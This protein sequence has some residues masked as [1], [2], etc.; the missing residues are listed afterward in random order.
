MGTGALALMWLTAHAHMLALPRA[1]PALAR[2]GR[3]LA[4]AGAARMGMGFEGVSSLMGAQAVS[5][6]GMALR[7]KPHAEGAPAA[8]V[9]TYSPRILANGGER[10]GLSPRER[11]VFDFLREVVRESGCG[12]VM[13][14]AGG[15]VRDK[16]LGLETDDID[17]ALDN[18]TGLCFARLLSESLEQTGEPLRIG[19]IQ[20]NPEQSKHLETVA[21]SI[22]GLSVDLVNLRSEEYSSE[23]RIPSEV[24]FG[25][26]LSDAQRRDL[27]I[28]SLFYNLRT[29]CIEDMTGRALADLEA[30][31]IDTPLAPKETL[32]DD[33]LRVLRAIRFA[34]RF[35]YSV[36]PA[37]REAMSD[38][39]VQAQLATKI[40]RERVLREVCSM[41]GA[42]GAAPVRAFRLLHELRL[43]EAVFLA[44]SLSSA[45]ASS[46]VA[47]DGAAERAARAH[48]A[49]RRLRSATGSLEVL[50]ALLCEGQGLVAD[51]RDPAAEVA[52]QRR[53][54]LAGQNAA[55]DSLGKQ[56][57]E[58]HED[59]GERRRLW[60]ATVL[61]PLRDAPVAAPGAQPAG[62]KRRKAPVPKFKSLAELIMRHGLKGMTA[63]DVTAILKMH[64]HSSDMGSLAETVTQRATE[65]GLPLGNPAL[66]PSRR[67]MGLAIRSA[68]QH[69]RACLQLDLVT[70]LAPLGPKPMADE[71]R[72]W[73]DH[74][75]T[76]SLIAAYATV[77]HAIVEQGLEDAWNMT[78]LINGNELMHLGVP[79]GRAVGLATSALIEWQLDHPAA[80][81]EEAVRWMR[82]RIEDERE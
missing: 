39:G 50:H 10:L 71:V 37:L 6:M 38:T 13:R 72:M 3:A 51:G 30:R 75:V 24:S 19:V 35:D 73:R 2:H 79:K 40:S 42:A 77:A 66:L 18:M 11:E 23:S 27:T 61:A 12:T 41:V 25:S 54:A 55:M 57:R 21:I 17:L 64:A 22:M 1:A 36:A 46:G 15:W 29:D 4:P 59:K 49:A 58:V 45:D 52:A 7:G 8:C 34:A 16:L 5:T 80:T 31:M 67:E 62:V 60:L 33:P 20:A 9:D 43:H 76:A 26:P 63:H 48:E 32:L 70:R 44:D 47:R 82:A 28:N 81:R 69:W 68:G 78:P 53:A 74:E 56:M 65:T 14:V